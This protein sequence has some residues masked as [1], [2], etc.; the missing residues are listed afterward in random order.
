M[1]ILLENPF[2]LIA[3][4][5]F[6]SSL[7]K[8]KKKGESEKQKKRPQQRPEPQ[9]E[10]SAAEVLMEKAVKEEKRQQAERASRIEEEYRRR[11]QQAEESIRVLQNQKL[12]A[13]RQASVFREPAEKPVDRPQARIQGQF[14]PQKKALVDGIIWSEILGPPRAKGPHR[15]L[16]RK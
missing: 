16:K 7:F 9:A 12:A 1:E 10:Q 2:I 13:E 8:K 11:K 6:I 14:A 4:L 15:S 3:L 5:A